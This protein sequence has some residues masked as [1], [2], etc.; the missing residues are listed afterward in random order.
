[1]NMNPDPDNSE[2]YEHGIVKIPMIDK[3]IGEFK[4]ENKDERKF[5]SGGLSNKDAVGNFFFNIHHTFSWTDVSVIWGKTVPKFI[6]SNHFPIRF[7]KSL[8][9]DD[10]QK[11]IDWHNKI[12]I[13]CYQKRYMHIDNIKNIQ[14]KTSKFRSECK[15]SC[16][17]PITI[18]LIDEYI[19]GFTDD[20]KRNIWNHGTTD[21]DHVYNFFFNI[22][23][24][25]N[26]C[27]SMIWNKAP[28]LLTNARIPVTF[29][30][31]LSDIDKQKV[32]DWHNNIVNSCHRVI[33]KM[34]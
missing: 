14:S 6:V 15:K 18:K 23:H 1:M 5:W 7:Y 32:I 30:K 21:W 10:K 29:Y 13:N 26:D 3:Y 8:S 19:S 34:N 31:R 20:A 12:A 9:D 4:D 24:T 28:I 11:L 17:G 27:V 22:Q 16:N 25:L 2:K 33:S